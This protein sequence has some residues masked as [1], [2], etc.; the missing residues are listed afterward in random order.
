MKAAFVG[1][2]DVVKF[3]AEQGADIHTRD[4]H[5]RTPLMRAAAHLDVVEYLVE[6]GADVNAQDVNGETPLKWAAVFGK[7]DVAEYL[8][9]NGADINARNVKGETPLN[10]A[11]EFG[12]QDV[13]RFLVRQGAV[14]RD[15]DGGY[16]QQ[17][18]IRIAQG[19]SPDGLN[20]WLLEARLAD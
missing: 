13:A 5:G 20:R 16:N 1:H 17:A 12:R 18:P 15:E 4:E 11:M 19:R 8:V 10:W 3:L 9:T 2:L 7:L 14:A 6:Q